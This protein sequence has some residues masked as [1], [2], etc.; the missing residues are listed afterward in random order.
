MTDIVDLVL[1][2]MTTAPGRA[3]A[4]IERAAQ[5]SAAGVPNAAIAVVLTDSS[6]KLGNNN[7]YDAKGVETIVN[8]WAD[9][10]KGTPIA[11]P[12][13]NALVKDQQDNGGALP[14]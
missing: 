6:K 2:K 3:G 13:A 14:A 5:M 12:V 7:E 9:A 1:S 11:K 8:L 10:Q 4:A